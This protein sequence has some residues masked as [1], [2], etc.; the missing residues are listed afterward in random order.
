VPDYA[1]IAQILLYS[2]GFNDATQLARKMVRLYSL[3]SEQLSKQ[4]HYDFGMRAVKSVLVMAGQLKRKNPN[5]GEDVTLIRALRDSN[6]PKFLSSD[7]PLFSGII[8]DLYPDAD[9]PFVDYGS[10]QKEIE[11]QLRVAKLQ[12]VPAFVGKIIQLLETQ[13]V[14]HGVMVVGLTQIGK[15]TKIST[16]AKALSKLRK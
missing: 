3:S 16:L 2:E 4:D 12:A 14:R 9:V 6:V 8:S 13:L 10:L 11:N 15:S 5:L 1:L 7:L